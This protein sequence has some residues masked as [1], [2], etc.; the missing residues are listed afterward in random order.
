LITNVEMYFQA[1]IIDNNTFTIPQAYP[2]SLFTEATHD[3]SCDGTATA[4]ASSSSGANLYYNWE[5]GQTT[6]IAVG[7][8]AGEYLVTV[9][10]GNG[11]SK[12][13]LATVFPQ[14]NVQFSNTE[15]DGLCN[16]TATATIFGGTPPYTYSWS[17]SGQE[18]ETASDLCAGE[19]V[20][21]V[22]DANSCIITKTTTV[23][24]LT[25]IVEIPLP[26]M[27]LFPNPTKDFITVRLDG[28]NPNNRIAVIHDMRGQLISQEKFDSDLLQVDLTSFEKGVYFIS[29]QDGERTIRK[30]VVKIN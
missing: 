14:L 10:D 19:Y 17:T 15:D 8:C 3:C 24:L 25:D 9:S 28:M 6:E 23:S 11:C 21:E 13:E 18:T 7:L 30:K 5:D 12:V 1:T 20:L 26:E 4:N 2:V 29:V 16:G 22:A 27:L